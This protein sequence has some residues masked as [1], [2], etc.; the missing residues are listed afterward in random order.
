MLGFLRQKDLEIMPRDRTCATN[1]PT[2]PVMANKKEAK[3][4]QSWQTKILSG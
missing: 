3:N 2:H 4:Q 1:I